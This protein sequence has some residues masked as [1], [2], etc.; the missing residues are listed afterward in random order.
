MS[1]PTPEQFAATQKASL[2]ALFGLTTKAFEG[3]VKLAEL[4]I[5]T[6]RAAIA[7]GQ[8]HAQR[9]L[10]SKDPQGFFALQAGFAQPAAEKALAYGRNVYAIVSA[11]QSEFTQ[12][13]QS[14]IEQQQHAVQTFVDNAAKNAPAGSETAVAAFKSAIT[15]A[16]GA[17]DSVNKAAKQAAEMAETNFDAV[18][19]AASKAAA[20]ATR[21]AKQAA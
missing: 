6:A 15:A 10:S 11:A 13:A 14:Q 3:A 19:K 12:A 7:E 8:E 18:T 4:N 16:Q 17:Y 1:L 2:E 20:Q 5:E 9:S 21:A